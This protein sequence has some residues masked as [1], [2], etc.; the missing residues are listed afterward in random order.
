MGFI[1][2]RGGLAELNEMIE[3]NRST[4]F[5]TVRLGRQHTDTV[6]PRN[7]FSSIFDSASPGSVTSPNHRSIVPLNGKGRPKRI[8][9]PLVGT[10][11]FNC[12]EPSGGKTPSPQETVFDEVVIRRNVTRSGTVRHPHQHKTHRPV[13]RN[14]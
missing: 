7:K 11:R 8:G 13:S 1:N 12:F 2:G 6:F 3:F 10:R 14:Q 9:Q 4:F 5:R